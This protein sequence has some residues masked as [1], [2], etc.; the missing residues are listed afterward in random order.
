MLFCGQ[1][2]DDDIEMVVMIPRD[3]RSP[4]PLANIRALTI[5]PRALIVCVTQFLNQLARALPR[6]TV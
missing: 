5:S 3:P 1:R 6:P 2:S 4:K